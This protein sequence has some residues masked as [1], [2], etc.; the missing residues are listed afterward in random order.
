MSNR[1]ASPEVGSSD[2]SHGHPH[3]L[4]IPGDQSFAFGRPCNTGKTLP[5]F[6]NRDRATT[7]RPPDAFSFEDHPL[8]LQ[9][10]V[11]DP[12]PVSLQSNPAYHSFQEETRQNEQCTNDKN[13][14]QAQH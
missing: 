14:R 6:S 8:Q 13:D 9:L 12:I 7:I 11:K 10:V 2:L 5:C 3:R 1:F 4:L